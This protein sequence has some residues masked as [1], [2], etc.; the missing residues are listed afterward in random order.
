[1]KN[2][3]STITLTLP[4]DDLIP[5]RDG[6]RREAATSEKVAVGLRE[7]VNLRRTLGRPWN[8]ALTGAI[9]WERKARIAY[10]RAREYHNLY[11]TRVAENRAENS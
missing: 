2:Q 3:A 6:L 9:F 11:W 1:M 4:L 5:L 10:D 8:L 7:K